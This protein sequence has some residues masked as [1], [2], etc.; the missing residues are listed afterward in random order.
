MLL[1]SVAI[2]SIHTTPFSGHE[3]IWSDAGLNFRAAHLKVRS[4]Q[5]VPQHVGR[6]RQS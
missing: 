6:L 2:S 4:G 3:A 1:M 5:L